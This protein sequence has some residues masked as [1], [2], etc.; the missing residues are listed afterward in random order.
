GQLVTAAPDPRD[1][2]VAARRPVERGDRRPA[3]KGRR[4]GAHRVV[5]VGRAAQRHLRERLARGRA[6][7][8]VGAAAA[9]AP[10][11]ADVHQLLTHGLLPPR[12]RP[13]RAPVTSRSSRCRTPRAT[14]PRT[15]G[16]ARAA[17]PA[18]S[19][20][21]ARIPTARP[22]TP[23]PPRT[24]APPPRSGPPPARLPRSRTR[25]AAPWPARP[26]APPG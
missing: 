3:G 17:P 9:L 19:G 2:R 6:D 14:G 24:P 1:D 25:C 21:P 8:G 12:G 23:R 26:A 13:Q 16:Q 22:R 4:G 15:G 20:T 5:H 10:L 18:A 7:R 11:P